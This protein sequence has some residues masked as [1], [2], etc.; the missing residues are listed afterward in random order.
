MTTGKVKWFDAEKGYGF[1]VPDVKGDDIFLH[2]SSVVDTS[3]IPKEGDQVTF[4]VVPGR[5]GK[6]QA[7]KVSKI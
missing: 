6:T 1:I 2:R 3:Y 5:K 7:G 4:E